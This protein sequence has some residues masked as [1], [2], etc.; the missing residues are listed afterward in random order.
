MTARLKALERYLACLRA[1]AA[2]YPVAEDF[3]DG[4][5][6]ALERGDS[7]PEFLDLVE[8]AARVAVPVL[9]VAPIDAYLKQCARDSRIPDPNRIVTAI[10][11]GYA[12]AN[13][14]GMNGETCTCPAR[15]RLMK[16][17]PSRGDASG[18]DRE[19]PSLMTRI[20]RSLEGMGQS[21]PPT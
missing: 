19:G 6:Q 2:L 8:A 4:W 12:E 3:A 18:G 1:Q 9:A 14:I 16:P 21:L 10:V 5:Q 7:L 11:H 15:E 17:R 13:L 20:A